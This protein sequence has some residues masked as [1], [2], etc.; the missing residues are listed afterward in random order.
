M[1]PGTDI[2]VKEYQ[3][4]GKWGAFQ[5]DCL[6][7]NS[8]RH[9]HGGWLNHEGCAICDAIYVTIPPGHSY[10]FLPLCQTIQTDGCNAL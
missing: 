1:W 7:G 9:L 8:R 6:E 2:S 5:D 10:S 3:G 4:K